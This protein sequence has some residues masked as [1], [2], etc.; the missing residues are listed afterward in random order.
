[1]GLRPSRRGGWEKQEAK[2]L[3]WV[4]RANT[5][6]PMIGSTENKEHEHG[7]RKAR[8]RERDLDENCRRLRGGKAGRW[9]T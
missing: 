9:K 4:Y 2:T 8:V 1:M 7:A 5:G 6:A 3:E